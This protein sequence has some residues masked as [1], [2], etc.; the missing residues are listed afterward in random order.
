MQ[1]RLAWSLLAATLTS[2][3]HGWVP[4]SASSSSYRA[5]SSKGNPF[6]ST[7]SAESSTETRL[8]EEA[9]GDDVILSHGAISKLPFRDLQ[10]ELEGRDLEAMGTTAQLRTRLRE[11]ALGVEEA[12]TVTDTMDEEACEVSYCGGGWPL[13]IEILSPTS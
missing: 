1:Y 6:S 2:S 10:K 5:V 8:S 7:V 9:S 3:S 11:A 12:C 4:S 13:T